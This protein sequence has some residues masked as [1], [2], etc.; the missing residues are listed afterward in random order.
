MNT[1]ISPL[2]STIITVLASVP[3]LSCRLLKPI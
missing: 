3:A 2:H 1:V